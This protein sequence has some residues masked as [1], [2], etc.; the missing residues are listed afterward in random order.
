MGDWFW[1]TGLLVWCY[2][3]FKLGLFI[4]YQFFYDGRQKLQ[5]LAGKRGSTWAVVTGSSYGIGRALAV[6]LGELGFNVVLIARSRDKL[7]EVA[8][9]IQA[10]GGRCII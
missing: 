1:W 6:A 5:R 10:F 2:A 7:E 4:Y 8:K 3:L 9:E